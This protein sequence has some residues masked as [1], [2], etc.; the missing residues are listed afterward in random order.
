MVHIQ[1]TNSVECTKIVTLLTLSQIICSSM[2]CIWFD[3]TVSDIS[4]ISLKRAYFLRVNSWTPSKRILQTGIKWATFPWMVYLTKEQQLCIAQGDTQ[5]VYLANINTSVNLPSVCLV[6]VTA[7][8]QL[9]SL[10]TLHTTCLCQSTHITCVHIQTCCVCVTIH[11]N[12][13]TSLN[14]L[15]K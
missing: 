14:T 13:I 10:T 3:Q 15:N 2:H 12:T 11:T 5:L 1:N 6:I 8:P 4:T 7:F 9:M